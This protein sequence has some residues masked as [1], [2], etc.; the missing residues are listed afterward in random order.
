VVAELCVLSNVTVAFG[1]LKA[2]DDVSLTLHDD[3]GIAGM[4]GPNGAGKST[5]LKV[6]AGALKPTSGNV[7]VLGHRLRGKPNT[8]KVARE[9]VARTF[10]I[11]R[12]FARMSVR[13]NVL[14]AR[15][16]TLRR[17][18]GDP[19]AEVDELLERMDLSDVADKLAGSLP[20]AAR[21]KLE[22]ARAMAIEPKLLLLD[23]VFEGLSDTEIQEL[24]G[25]LRDLHESGIK[26]LLVE[27]VLRA[28]RQLATYLV[29]LDKGCLIAEGEV[30]EVLCSDCVKE[31][32]LGFGGA[33]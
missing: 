3:S 5:C 32:Y 6:I 27:H 18:R 20:L 30:E 31:A 14:V 12:P 7:E 25:I 2:I 1:G 29:V 17:G 26:L 33:T 28:L 16:A 13:E 11:P 4:I 22:V 19:Q 9:G 15:L 8:A 23:E 21:K 24:V 10:Q